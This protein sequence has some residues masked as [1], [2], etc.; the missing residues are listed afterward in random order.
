[1]KTIMRL[2]L[3]C[4]ICLISSLSV[5]AAETITLVAD[6]WPPFNSEPNR[7]PEGYM[8]DI[9]REIFKAHGIDVVYQLVP[10]KRALEGTCNGDYNAVIGP[11]KNEA[12]CLVFPGEELARNRLS[13]WDKKGNP[14]RFKNR[15]AVKQITLGVIE[16]Y[17]YRQWLNSYAQNNR[18]DQQKIQF[19]SGT[20]PLEMN[21]R[22]LMA[23]NIGAVVDNEASIRYTA[24]EVGLLEHIEQVGNDTETAYLFIAFSPVQPRSTTYARILSD[25]IVKLRKNGGLRKILAVYG[26]KDWK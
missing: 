26:L 12:P 22:K 8:V 4:L 23:G 19:V 24:K 11:T 17:D 13:F 2:V 15:D 10:W 1:M 9:A 3:V 14:W 5:A 6:E 21:L 20:N 16:G 7:Q 25:G 18:N